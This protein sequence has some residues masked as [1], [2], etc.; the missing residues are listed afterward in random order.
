[1]RD[2]RNFEE[3][4][5]KIRWVGEVLEEAT[6]TVD[7]DDGGYAV[8]SKNCRGLLRV[9]STFHRLLRRWDVVATKR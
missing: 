2:G 8:M 7:L 3:N 4:Y 9:K 6:K 1:M 5:N